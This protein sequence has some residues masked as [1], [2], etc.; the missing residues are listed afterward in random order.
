MKSFGEPGRPGVQL[1]FFAYCDNGGVIRGKSTHVSSLERRM[2]SGI[3]LSVAM[4]A[5][6]D[7]DLLVPMEG[8]GPAGEVRIVADPETFSV[9]PYAPK[10]ASMMADLLKLDRDPWEAMHP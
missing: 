6:T 8:M 1:V 5:V 3:G 7:M 2:D 4:Q 10:R 9:L